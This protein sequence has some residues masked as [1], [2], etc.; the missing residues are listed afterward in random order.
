MVK[1]EIKV[2]RDMRRG[3]KG[4][5]YQF[6]LNKMR[7]KTRGEEIKYTK[8]ERKQISKRRG[9]GAEESRVAKGEVG[10]TRGK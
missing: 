2:R 10:K 1:E 9:R 5:E 7:Q 3:Q 6:W 8:W 4:K